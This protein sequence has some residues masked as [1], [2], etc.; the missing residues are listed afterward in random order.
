MNGLKMNGGRALGERR[1]ELETSICPPPAWICEAIN[2]ATPEIL[3]AELDDAT[4]AY[5]VA[6]RAP[7][8]LLRQGIGQVAGLMVLA[9]AGARSAP[10]HPMLEPASAAH[11]AAQDAIRAASAPPQGVHHHD[12]LARAGSA[13]EAALKAARLNMHRRDSVSLDAVMVPLRVAHSELQRST[14]ALPGFEIV[15]LSQCCCAAPSGAS[16]R[17]RSEASL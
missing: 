2:E 8:D 10:A 15:A 3:K 14:F 11:A 6:M 1:A 16:V 13:L 4:I 5:I 12:H 17:A 9:A 7:F